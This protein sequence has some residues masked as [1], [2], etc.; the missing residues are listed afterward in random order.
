MKNR[1]RNKLNNL[2]NINNQYLEKEVEK[3]IVGQ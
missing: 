2:F 3:M 1:K